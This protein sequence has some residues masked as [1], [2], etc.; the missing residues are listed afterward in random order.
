MSILVKNM[1]PNVLSHKR[2]KNNHLLFKGALDDLKPK[3][4]F[5]IFEEITQI[6]KE[7]GHN[8]EISEYIEKK[9]K[10]AQFEVQ[11]KRS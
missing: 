11:I 3:D 9:L 1:Q 5:K 7:S 2:V 6:Y 8:K 10:D 4:V